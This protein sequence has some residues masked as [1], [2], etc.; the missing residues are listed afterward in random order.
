M[1]SEAR[2]KPIFKTNRGVYIAKLL[3]PALALEP[4]GSF[5]DRYGIDGYLD[6]FSVQIKYDSRIATSDNIYHEIYEKS[7]GR[8]DQ[9]WRKSPGIA[10]HYIFTTEYPDCYWGKLIEVDIL[11]NR[12]I[13]LCLTRINPNG[14]GYTSLG[15]IFPKNSCEGEV[16]EKQKEV[17]NAN[18]ST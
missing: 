4:E 15:F 10:T 18:F 2:V 5:W 1:K 14:L 7:E 12:E 8:P 16:R 6:H 13:G 3:W 17:K 11:A 9:P